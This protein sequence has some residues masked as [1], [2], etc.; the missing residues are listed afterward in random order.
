MT[1]T[2]EF[3]RLGVEAS[4]LTQRPGET[5]AAFWDRIWDSLNPEQRTRLN[6]ACAAVECRMVAEALGLPADAVVSVELNPSA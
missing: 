2:E 4:G 6:E 5:Q 1:I 3:H